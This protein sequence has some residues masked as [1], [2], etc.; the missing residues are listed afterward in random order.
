MADVPSGKGRVTTPR[1]PGSPLSGAA[2]AAARL[3]EE[4]DAK[5]R[6]RHPVPIV[7]DDEGRPLAAGDPLSCR[8]GARS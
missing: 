4:F 7:V 3:I 2:M 6:L 1:Q 8:R 5:Q